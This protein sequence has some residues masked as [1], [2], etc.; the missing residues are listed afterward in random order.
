MSKSHKQLISINSVALSAKLINKIY[1][2]YKIPRSERFYINTI[3]F[4]FIYKLR[5]LN[6]LL[7]RY[8]ILIDFRTLKKFIYCCIKEINS[9]LSMN[10]SHQK[11]VQLFLKSIGHL[12]FKEDSLMSFTNLQIDCCKKN[13][14][15]ILNQCS[16]L[17]IKSNK[18]TIM[19][20]STLFNFFYQKNIRYIPLELLVILVS[21]A[22]KIFYNNKELFNGSSQFNKF[23][24][25]NA[26]KLRVKTFGNKINVIGNNLHLRDKPPVKNSIN[27]I[28]FLSFISSITCSL[29]FLTDFFGYENWYK[30]FPLEQESDEY[31]QFDVYH[32]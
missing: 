8:K 13:K 27:E 24:L 6:D 11:V 7:D 5:K 28:Q 23:L 18:P 30:I 31:I 1:K 16:P 26:I 2:V 20:L 12:N 17:L 21:D 19:S 3:I 32:F 4:K 15:Y 29:P 9:F 25:E 14:E 10:I 22:Q